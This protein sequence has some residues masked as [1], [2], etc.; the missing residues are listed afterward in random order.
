ALEK[1]LDQP[2]RSRIKLKFVITKRPLPGITNPSKSGVKPIDYMYPVDLL[3]DK[4]EIDLSW[5]KNMIENY[6]Q[7]AFGLSGVA[8]TEQTG[9]DAWM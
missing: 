6:I 5:Y 2:I 4:S 3:K 9:L 7:G 1:L 8:A